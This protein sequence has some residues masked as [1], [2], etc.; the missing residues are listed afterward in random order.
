MPACTAGI[1]FIIRHDK[2]RISLHSQ[3]K[4]QSCTETEF[5][6]WGLHDDTVLCIGGR[7]FF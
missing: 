4:E 2:R 3:N 1:A 5:K 7:N 6:D